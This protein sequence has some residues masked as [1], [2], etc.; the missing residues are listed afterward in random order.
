MVPDDV[1][2]TR[3]WLPEEALVV[4][5]FHDVDPGA[6]LQAAE[7][8]VDGEA[9]EVV[10]P[11]KG[12]EPDRIGTGEGAHLHAWEAPA[13]VLIIDTDHGYRMAFAG[14]SSCQGRYSGTNPS[15]ARRGQLV[16]DENDSHGHAGGPV[17]S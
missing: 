16:A 2:D 10:F 11:E 3:D 6:S 9:S 5:P 12:A 1:D 13:V 4:G 7:F 8:P 15:S 17:R 14:K